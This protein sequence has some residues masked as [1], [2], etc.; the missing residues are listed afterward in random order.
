MRGRA[1]ISV[2]MQKSPRKQWLQAPGSRLQVRNN[3][4]RT[5]LLLLPKPV[6]RRPKP[7]LT[8]TLFFYRSETRLSW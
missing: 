2:I 8:G 5:R 3:M 7:A 4:S 1:T 6:A